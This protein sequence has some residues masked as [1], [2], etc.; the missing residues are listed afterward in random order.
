MPTK[1]TILLQLTF[2]ILA[3]TAL[4]GCDDQS[5]RP[6]TAQRQSF[7][8]QPVTATPGIED[9]KA[10]L[11]MNPND[12]ATLSTLADMY[13]EAGRYLE[14]INTYDKAIGVNAM[15]ADCYNDKGLALHY[16]GES[17]AAVAAFDK[18]VT[19][20]PTFV[21]AWLSKGFVLVSS[22]RFQE[23]IEPLNKVKELDTEGGLA[24]EADKFLVLIAERSTQ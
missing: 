7:D 12:F 20:D 9:L 21:H 5:S 18:A 15:C 6:A 1:N 24:A 11:A 14:A 4:N 23:A 10:V 16:L 3:F 13:F 17:D 8:T 19:I 22:G 2:V